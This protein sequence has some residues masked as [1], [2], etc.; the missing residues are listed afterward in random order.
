MDRNKVL[1]HAS[2]ISIAGNFFLAA[3]KITAGAAAGSMAVIADGLDSL[4]DV[5]I[6][7]VTLAA[8]F[9]IA[10]PPDREHPY[11]HY[12]AETL[13]TSILSFVI[14][15]IGLQLFIYSVT[16][17][18]SNEST[19]VPGILAIYVTIFSIAGK[20][21]LAWSQFYYSR[22]SDSIMLSAN[23]KNMLNDIITSAGVLAG[24]L[25]G[26]YFDIPMIDRILAAAIGLWIMFSAVSI[27]REVVVELMEG[28][29]THEFYD[30][31][32]ESVHQVDGALNPHRARI[33]RV[34]VM[35][36]I[37]LDIEVEGDMTVRD[38]HEISV[39]V[40]CKIKNRIDNVLDIVIHIEPLGNFEA[41]EGYGICADK[42]DH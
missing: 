3:V 26:Q 34:G 31:I 14:F 19:A 13:A 16:R 7:F 41:G 37:D 20:G 22:K 40:E 33:R 23:G 25:I 9:M 39:E 29:D 10:K 28:H 6:S 30:A 17:I 27:I 8:S 18:I 5:V 24:L 42:I 11:G 15:F 36:L 32:F 2:F 12:R 1:K 38:A 21:L 35:Y 4:T